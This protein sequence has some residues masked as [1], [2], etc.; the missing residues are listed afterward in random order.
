MDGLDGHF[1]YCWP[2]A[3]RFF[4][5]QRVVAADFAINVLPIAITL[6]LMR[7]LDPDHNAAKGAKVDMIGALLCTLGLA[8]SVFGLIEQTRYGWMNP[9]IFIPLVT[10]L[11][12]L[13]FFIWYESLQ[14]QPMLP[15]EL[16]KVRNFSVGNLAT[17]SIY[18][19]L[20][21][22][23]FLIVIFLQ[24]VGHYSALASGLALLPVTLLM[25]FL[26]PRFGS[27]AGKYGP[28]LFMALGPTIGGCG[29]LLLLIANQSAVYWTQIFPGIVLFGTGLSMTVAPLTEAV[30]GSIESRHAGIGS[31]VNNAI[32]RIA[33]LLAT[34]AI[35][36]VVGSQITLAGFQK[37]VVAMAILL[38]LGGL[39]SAIGIVNTHK[40][41]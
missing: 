18:A 31:A 17:A 13:A 26:S 32:A 38:I 33:G 30:L 23:T 7:L 9:I 19:G 27:L 10:G 21:V 11:G 25:F 1:V 37:G 41:R 34:A 40:H 16:F 28:R 3:R 15:L 24:Q 22:A 35:G 4:G 36:V 39:T 20:S 29:F 12:L 6:W 14:K 8:G 2:A 5:R